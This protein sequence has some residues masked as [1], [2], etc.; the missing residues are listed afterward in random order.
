M[1]LYHTDFFF[2]HLT[3]RSTRMGT[4]QPRRVVFRGAPVVY[5]LNLTIGVTV[6]PNDVRTFF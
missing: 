4:A 3:V 5:G 2:S 6:G 1:I